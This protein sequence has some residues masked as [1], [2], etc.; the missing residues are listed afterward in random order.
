MDKKR[1]LVVDDEP[2]FTHMVKLNL[3]KLQRYEVGV[4]NDA[5]QTLPTIRRFQPDLILLD[6]IMPHLDGGD[7]VRLLQADVQTR[8]L[9][10]IFLTAAVQTKEVSQSG[11]VIGGQRY[12]AKPV[13]LRALVE[14]IEQTLDGGFP[15]SPPLGSGSVTGL[16]L[17]RETP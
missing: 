15:A 16:G 10:V 13:S 7:V 17:T 5:R 12:L 2:S 11:G 9:P 8:N 6:V 14:T 1:I 3:E 4:E